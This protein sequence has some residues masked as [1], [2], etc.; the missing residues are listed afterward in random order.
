MRRLIQRAARGLTLIEVLVMVAIIGLLMAVLVFYLLGDDD[1]RC[2]LEA[3]RLAVFLTAASAESVMGD[4]PTRVAFNFEPQTCA[5]EVA[6]LK[7]GVSGGSWEPDA[8]ADPF[9]VRKPVRMTEVANAHGLLTAGTGWMIFNGQR[10]QGGVVVLTLNEAIWSV[11]VP[12]GPGDI[13]V[14]QGRVAL[15]PPASLRAGPIK[16]PLPPFPELPPGGLPSFPSAP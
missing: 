1:R 2:R 4:G 9:T 11:V 12:N 14:K 7:A 8:T 6:R 16:A 13:E 10:V 5:R 3:E 15:P